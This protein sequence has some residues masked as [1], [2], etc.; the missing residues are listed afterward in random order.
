MVCIVPTVRWPDPHA[1]E[2]LHLPGRRV[3]L[4]EDPAR[5]GHQRAPGLGDRDAPRG[6]FDQRQSD[7]LL[8]PADL[9]G[10]RGL[11][12]VLARGGAGEVLL[13]GQRDQVPELAKFHK[14][15]L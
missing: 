2:R 4:G 6:P 13:V 12:D 7:L 11:G 1:R 10:Q 9:L 3:D 5:A 14:Q 8:E 15:S